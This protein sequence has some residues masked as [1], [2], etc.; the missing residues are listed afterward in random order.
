MIETTET[1][2]LTILPAMHLPY[3]LSVVDAGY[4]RR[5]WTLIDRATGDSVGFDGSTGPESQCYRA[6]QVYGAEPTAE[7][8][9]L[10]VWWAYQ[11]MATVRL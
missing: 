6:G 7:Q 1:V 10:L 3:Y 11:L 4:G 5:Y 8:K 2:D 9:R